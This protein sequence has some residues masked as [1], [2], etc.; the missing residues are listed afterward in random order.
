MTKRWSLILAFALVYVLWGSTYAAIRVAIETLPP[1]LM[2]GTR[3]LIAGLILYAWAKWKEPR[4][5][6]TAI[7]WRSAAIIGALLLLGG[8]GMVVWAEFRIPSGLAAVLV[9][10]VPLWMSALDRSSDK[11]DGRLWAGLLLGFGGVCLLFGP[12]AW[13]GGTQ[14]DLLGCLAVLLASFSWSIGSLYSKRAS[15]PR[16]TFMATAMEMISGG[17]LLMLLGSLCGEWTAVHP[18]T[19][20]AKSIGALVYLIIFG[21]IIGFTAYFWLLKNTTIARA[22]T[23]AY[24]NPVIALLLGALFM[25]E[26]FTLRSLLAS[27]LTLSGVALI[28]GRR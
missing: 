24:V 4:E 10:T 20:S 9:S 26:P 2:A 1:F 13:L 17:A 25:S 28:L 14:P 23:Y 16:S 18:E 6:L 12:T 15:L 11:R 3:F 5:T 8:N 22:S 7:H 27:G 19:M 21:S